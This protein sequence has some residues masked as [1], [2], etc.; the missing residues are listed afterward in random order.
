MINVVYTSLILSLYSGFINSKAQSEEVLI[1]PES[2]AWV[3]SIVNIST[4]FFS[5]IVKLFATLIK[6]LDAF[7][8]SFALI[9]VKI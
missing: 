7:K 6:F 3:H 9:Y 8:E 1:K 5:N 4:T 2:D